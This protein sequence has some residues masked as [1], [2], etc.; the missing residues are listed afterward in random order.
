MPLYNPPA[1]QSANGIAVDAQGF[2]TFPNDAN[3]RPFKVT[4]DPADAAHTIITI[5][6]GVT[7]KV[8]YTADTP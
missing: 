8:I 4:K 3:A 7:E 1:T 6:D 5:K 2:V